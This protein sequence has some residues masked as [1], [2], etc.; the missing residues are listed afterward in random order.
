MTIEPCPTC[1]TPVRVVGD[2]FGEG[3]THY[4]PVG[5]DALVRPEVLAFALAM[6]AKLKANDH[7]GGWQSMTITELV[8][9][10]RD[11][12]SELR[13]AI[14]HDEGSGHGLTHFDIPS[15]AAD[16]ANFAMMIFDVSSLAARAVQGGGE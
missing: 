5:L 14:S 16:V 3:T 11:E 15:E 10:L 6:E 13:W 7:K 4:E 1:G 2:V 8:K 12:L 9:R